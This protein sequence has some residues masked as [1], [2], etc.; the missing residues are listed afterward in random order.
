MA[1][2]DFCR[3]EIGA[4][5]KTVRK[6]MKLCQTSFGKP[7]GLS[8]SSI[9]Y[10]EQGYI[11]NKNCIA[12]CQCYNINVKW[13]VDGEGDMFA[14]PK[15]ATKDEIIDTVKNTLHLP[16]IAVDILQAYVRLTAS[17][18]QLVDHAIQVLIKA[19]KRGPA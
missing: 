10:F 12:I 3:P 17:E 15:T 9:S 11:N 7:L 2:E 14:P 6:Q 18:K 19:S 4:R 16:P 13:L 8:T 5:L 1:R